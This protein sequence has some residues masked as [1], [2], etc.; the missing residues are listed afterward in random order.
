MGHVTGDVSFE[1]LTIAVLTVSDT[2]DLDT[3]TSGD[4]LSERL[5]RA[6]HAVGGRVVVRDDIYQI[7]AQASKWIADSSSVTNPA[8]SVSVAVPT[9]R[10][11]T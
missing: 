3:D 6:G 5:T 4:V 7:R 2:R 10:G 9:A 8:V 11:V 1:P